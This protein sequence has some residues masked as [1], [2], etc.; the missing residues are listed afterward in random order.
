MLDDT[1]DK[2]IASR[3]VIVATSTPEGRSAI[4][5]VRVSGPDAG[6]FV[7]R[8]FRSSEPYSP[9]HARFGTFGPPGGAPVDKVVLTVFE[10]PRSYTG[11]DVAE[12]SAHGNPLILNQIEG[13]L[14]SAG[15]RRA[16]R[17]EFTLRAVSNGKMDLAQAEAVRDF[18]EAETTAQARAA[19]RQM[20]GAV[21]HRVR[22]ERE[23]LVAVV[24]ELEA[25]IDFAEDD[26]DPGVPEDTAGRIGALTRSLTE[27]AATFDYGKLLTG[28]L[29]VAIMG[30][31]NVGKS[32][33]F[34][35]LL[36]NDR[37]IVTDIPGTTRD[38][39][40]ETIV[41][42]DIPLRIAD[43]AGVRRTDEA[44]EAIGV[45][46]TLETAAEADLIVLV[47]DGSE[48]LSA[49][50]HELLGRCE[51]ARTIVAINKRDRPP[52]WKTAAVGRRPIVGLSA[53]SGEGFGDL[54]RAMAD[55]LRERRPAPSD[56]FVITSVRQREALTGAAT[57]AGK[58]AAALI[59]G[60]PHEMVLVDL[61]RALAD[62]GEVTGEITN[63]DILDQIFSA[64]CIGK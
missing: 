57:H 24:A 59:G 54:E 8:F 60:V 12:I 62:L 50:D 38:V 43:T 17:G 21:A 23:A 48:A 39:L 30:R 9:R 31:P 51:G 52:A 15:A 27:M 53:L 2:L 63:D 13:L 40:T 64:F 55:W 14:V 45:R 36:S 28:G 16:R 6:P 37:A 49:E 58:A 33:L 35:R 1:R 47:L 3:D 7:E 10:G 29:L 32:S 11:E 44:V 61:Y 42:S 18:V 19:L 25:G 34:N 4:G 56:G 22:R 26:I 41:I 5:I 46:R 20:E